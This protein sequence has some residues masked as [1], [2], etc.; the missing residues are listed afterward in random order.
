MDYVPVYADDEPATGQ[1]RISLDKVQKLG[2]RS[3]PVA[4]RELART[5]RAVG[6]LQPDERRIV[7]VTDNHLCHLWHA[8]EGQPIAPSLPHYAPAGLP[9]FTMPF[10]GCPGG[11]GTNRRSHTSEVLPSALV[12]VPVFPA[13]ENS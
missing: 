8:T 5:V 11:P 6:R 2:V 9:K 12:A 1:L 13:I 10:S 7:T 3:E 4:S